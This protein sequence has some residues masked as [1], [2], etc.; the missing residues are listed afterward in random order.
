MDEK[1]RPEKNA[2]AVVPRHDG[3]DS[4][5]NGN[6]GATKVQEVLRKRQSLSDVFTI[7]SLSPD[8]GSIVI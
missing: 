5:D 6:P 2:A 4:N 1:T 3:G 7:A 8:G